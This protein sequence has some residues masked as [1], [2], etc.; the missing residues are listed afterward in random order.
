MKLNWHTIKVLCRRDLKAYFS[1]PT[2]Y[3]F[4]TLFIFLSAAAAFWQQRFFADNLANLA[5]LNN[6]FPFILLF[7]VPALTM[8]VWADER[9]QGTDELL[10]TLPA[11]DLEVVLGKYLAVLGIYT[12]S[13]LF[14][15]SHVAVLWWLGSPDLGLMFGNY[16]GYWFIGAALLAVGMLAS[17]LTANTT[18]GFILGALF[19]GVLVFVDSRT[20]VLAGWLQGLLAPLAVTQYFRDFARGV[21]SLSGVVF[22]VSLAA[23]ALYGNVLLIGR[24]HWPT[25]GD[26][27]QFWF[28]QLVRVVALVIAVMSFNVILDRIGFRIDV[29]AERLHSLSD[30]T[31]QLIDEISEDRPVLVQAFISPE[32]PRDYVEV[33]ENLLNALQEIGAV[34]GDRVQVLIHDTEPYSQE[35]RDAREKFGI[36]PREVLSRE[37]ARISSAQVFLGVAATS[38]AAEEV[39]PFFDVGLPVEYELTRTIRVAAKTD[40]KRIGVLQ[41]AAEVAGG[42]DYATMQSKNPWAIVTE[43]RKQYDVQTLSADEPITGDLDGLLVILPS[44]LTQPQMDNLKTYMTAGNPTLLLVDPLPM[45][46][47]SLSPMVPAGAQTNPFQRNQQQPPPK[48]DVRGLLDAVGVKWQPSQVIW[49]SYNPH[50]DFVSLPPEF[51]FVGKGNESAEAFNGEQA[52]SSGLQEVVTIYGGYIFKSTAKPYQ[53]DPLIRT[54]RLSGVLD[55]TQL[56]QRGFFG[57]QLNR[58]PRR[59]PTGESY[60]LAAHVQGSEGPDTTMGES[61]PDRVNAIVV[62]DVDVISD[63]FFMFRQ[64]GAGTINFDNVSFVLNCMD[65]LVGDSSFIDLRKKRVKHR[66]LETVEARTQ[67]YVERRMEEERQAETEAQS[68]LAEAQQTLDQKV[69]EVRNREDLDAQAKRIMT[70]NL[71]EVE[72]RRFNVVKTNIEA[73]KQATIAASKENMEEAIRQIQSRI[74]TLAVLLPPIPVFVIG[75]V[76]LFRRRKRENEGAAAAR[77]LRS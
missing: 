54:G 33:R 53:F 24:R 25:R 13:L 5:Q 57:L 11:T 3:V 38:G 58:N 62:A 68:A 10:L 35:A 75:L 29:T 23:V 44:S 8:S 14:S 34:G 51:V 36:V 31:E 12:A 37:S 16:L 45:I 69:A 46:D 56:V 28:H 70:Q 4:V 50:P 21:V 48:G 1:S 76:T 40:R 63:Q 47:P 18:V 61:V 66:T 67:V 73:R 15:L 49:D 52:A 22:F 7:F 39:I 26:R 72:S 74:K 64:S 77:R 19:C 6:L 41:T 59:T 27:R 71:Q 2:G 65:V 20:V 60:I 42:F 9:K 32:V 17:M 43:L 55:W 30:R